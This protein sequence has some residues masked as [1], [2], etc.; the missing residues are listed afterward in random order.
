MKA[1]EALTGIAPQRRIGVFR[2]LTKMF[3][4][5]VVGSAEQV[6]AYFVANEEKQRGEFVVIVEGE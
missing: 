2:E 1:L 6:L 3:E 4:E 5:S